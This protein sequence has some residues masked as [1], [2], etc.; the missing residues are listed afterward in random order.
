MVLSVEARRLSNQGWEV[1]TQS[2]R[3]RSG[4][5]VVEWVTE[6]VYRGAGEIF[7]TSVDREGTRKG[8]DIDL[9]RAVSQAVD[10][11]VIA[12]GGMGIPDDAIHAVITGGADAVAMADILH[13]QRAT[14]GDIR[15]VCL[16]AGLQVRPY[17]Q[18]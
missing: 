10:V 18:A 14:I 5:D 7:L 1:L 11:P 15:N 8:F 12:S 3:E 2:G 16:S 9:L 17:D 4:R 13:Y 6:A